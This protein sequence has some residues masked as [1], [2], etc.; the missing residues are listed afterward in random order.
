MARVTIWNNHPKLHS[1]ILVT[2]S[3]LHSNMLKLPTTFC[4]ALTTTH[5]TLATAYQYPGNCLSKY[6]TEPWQPSKTITV[7]IKNSFSVAQYSSN[8]LATSHCTAAHS[9]VSQTSWTSGLFR[10]LMN[11]FNFFIRFRFYCLNFSRF[12]FYC[13]NSSGFRFS[14]VNIFFWIPFFFFR[15][16]IFLDSILMV[17]LNVINHQ[18]M[19]Y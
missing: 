2:S 10:A 5:S 1:N 19:S 16:W 18:S 8:A 17:K 11:P 13:L 6:R 4:N 14:P 9:H 7:P 12:R 3:N 15:L